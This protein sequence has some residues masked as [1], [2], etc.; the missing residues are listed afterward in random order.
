MGDWKSREE[1][2][3]YYF[4]ILSAVFQ[5]EQG[6]EFSSLEEAFEGVLE[7]SEYVLFSPIR[8]S[9]YLL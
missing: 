3:I 6:E 7:L 1:T 8:S 9:Q 4:L 2:L 5:K